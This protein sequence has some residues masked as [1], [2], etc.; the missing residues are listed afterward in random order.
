MIKPRA[1]YKLGK[2]ELQTQPFLVFCF[3]LFEDTEILSLQNIQ[4]L[5]LDASIYK[6]FRQFDTEE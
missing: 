2:L 5:F 6:C 4:V 1:S 3:V